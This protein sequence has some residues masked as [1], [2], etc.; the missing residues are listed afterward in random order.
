MSVNSYSYSGSS[1]M[2]GPKLNSL[3]QSLYSAS[4]GASANRVVG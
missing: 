3:A 4:Q 2:H 1:G